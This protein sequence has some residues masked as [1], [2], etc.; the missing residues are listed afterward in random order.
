MKR[1]PL[2]IGTCWSLTACTGTY[3]L[4]AGCTGTSPLPPAHGTVD[5]ISDTGKSI[6]VQVEVADDDAERTRGLMFKEHLAPKTGMLFVFDAPSPLSFWMR[7]TLIPLD[8]LYFDGE[9]RFVSSATMLPCPE[10][11]CPL[12]P[13][14]GPAK[15]ALEVPMG[16]IREEQVGP[17]WR[18]SE[19]SLRLI[20]P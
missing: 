20:A 8:I 5:L 3:I 1:T 7:N 12:Y 17:G 6:S 10:G 18:I 14:Q 4:L 11:P 13:S 19:R 15:Y 16:F 2:Q 9:G